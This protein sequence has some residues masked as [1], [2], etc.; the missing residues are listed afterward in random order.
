MLWCGGS[1]VGV[2]IFVWRGVIGELGE[3]LALGVAEE[4]VERVVSYFPMNVIFDR[5][6]QEK[7]IH[8]S[9]NA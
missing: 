5:S 1:G 3:L 9:M 8:S 6:H 4:V 2:A 7:V